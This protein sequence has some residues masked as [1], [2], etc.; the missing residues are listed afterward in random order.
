MITLLC[1]QYPLQLLLFSRARDVELA[2]R[3]SPTLGREITS[4]E[5]RPL[6][7]AASL[8]LKHRGR[9]THSIT[10]VYWLSYQAIIVIE[11]TH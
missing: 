11:E 3:T 10:S 8:N 1:W 9:K 4:E 7:K 2:R 5:K 6:I